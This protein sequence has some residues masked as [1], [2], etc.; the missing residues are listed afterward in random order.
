MRFYSKE[1]TRSFSQVDFIFI[2]TTQQEHI[3]RIRLNRPEKRNAFTPTMADEIAYALAYAHYREDVWCVIVEAE[4]PVFC[5]GADLNAFHDS[6][7]DTKNT[8]MPKPRVSVT[9]GDAFLELVKPCIAQVEGAVL[10]GGFLLIAGCTF[11]VSVPDATYGLPEVKRGIWPMQVM[12]SLLRILP[13]RKV[14]EICITG[15]SFSAE[16]ALTMGLVTRVVEKAEIQ[17]KVEELARQICQNAPLAIRVGMETINQLGEVPERRKH[18]FLK[19]QLE[20]ILESDDAKEGISAFKEKR[21]PVWKG[22]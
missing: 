20:K 9:L 15:N 7:V 5:A 18:A 1:D 8:T 4:G 12:A 16:E 3:F 11:V 6:S 13:P 21:L 2:R 22:K 10:A 17:A 14:L 19:A